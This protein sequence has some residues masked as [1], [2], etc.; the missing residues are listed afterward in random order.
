[1]NTDHIDLK[2]DFAF[3]PIFGRGGQEPVMVACA[4]RAGVFR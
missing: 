4:I 2:I 3:K 1:M